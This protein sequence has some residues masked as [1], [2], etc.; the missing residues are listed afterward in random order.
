MKF[1]I[2]DDDELYSIHQSILETFD[3]VWI[4]ID[5]DYVL[6]LLKNAGASVEKEKKIVRIPSYLV[7]EAIRGSPKIFTL[8]GKDKDHRVKLEK[9]KVYSVLSSTTP[10]VMDLNTGARIHRTKEYI[11]KAARIA[12]ALPNYHVVPQFC[13]A[14]D[15]SSTLGYAQDLRELEAV[16][17]N[18]SKPVM[19]LFYSSETSKDF[20]DMLSLL[21][22]GIDEL[23]KKPRAFAYVEPSSPLEYSKEAVGIMVEWAKEGLPILCV[24]IVQSGATGPVTLAGTLVQSFVESLTGL[25]IIHLIRKGTPFIIGAVST[26]LD[27]KTGVMAY[28]APEFSVINA[29]ASQLAKYYGLP[30]FGTGGCSDS[31][32]IDGQAVGES[33]TSLLFAM[34][35]HTNLI[36]DQG[37]IESGLTGSLE[38]VVIDN[39][40]FGMCKRIV[41]GM[42]INDESLAVDLIEKVGPRGHYLGEKHTLK[43]MLEEHWMPS[44]MDRSPYSKWCGSGGKDLALRARERALKILKEHQPEPIPKDIHGELIHIIEKREKIIRNKY[45]QKGK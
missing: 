38:M 35:S 10:N 3:K 41:D 16:V 40:L 45:N 23:R 43:H 33:A 31:K 21:A 14:M 20:I 18:T 42:K 44:L 29:A 24:P 11:G 26:V 7:E 6:D 2:L 1:S 36:H 32:V 25:V 12:D 15:Y 39:E 37:Y 8:Y 34:L 17:S 19:G 9:D 28:G 4:R 5:D 27:M 22:G 30:F 13:L